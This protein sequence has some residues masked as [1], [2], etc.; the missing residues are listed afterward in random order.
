M[1]DDLSPELE[2]FSRRR[3]EIGEGIAA[4]ERALSAPAGSKLWQPRLVAALEELRR[5]AA[6]QYQAVT[7]PEGLFAEIRQEHP[8]LAAQTDQIQA[9]FKEAVGKL[10]ELI[11]LASGLPPV[12]LRRRAL[13][14][15]GTA[16]ELRQRIADVVWE[17]YWIDVGG[18]G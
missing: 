15:L 13:G 10:E 6:A 9:D 14:L 7:E 12:E 2:G 8:D 5:L 16:V 3:R 4:V 17:A 11:P 18:P 1:S